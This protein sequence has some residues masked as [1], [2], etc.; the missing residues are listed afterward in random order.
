ME[1]KIPEVLEGEIQAS[2]E[3]FYVSEYKHKSKYIFYIV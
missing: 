3:T 1:K 2:V